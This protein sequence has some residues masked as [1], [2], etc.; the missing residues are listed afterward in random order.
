[1]NA[2]TRVK[3]AKR[4]D[5]SIPDQSV[6]GMEKSHGSVTPCGITNGLK[7]VAVI[8]KNKTI[9]KICIFFMNFTF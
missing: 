6:L 3:I 1:V 4:I 8:N 2:A 9:N 7:V 5:M